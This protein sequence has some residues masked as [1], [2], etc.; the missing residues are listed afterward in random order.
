MEA[1]VGRAAL[2]LLSRAGAPGL[3]GRVWT[4]V[5][6]HSWELAGSEAWALE[7]SPG[8]LGS[9]RLPLWNSRRAAPTAMVAVHSPP[10]P[11]PPGL[12]GAPPTPANRAGQPTSKLPWPEEQ[13]DPR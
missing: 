9:A 13:A 4:R 12:R 10:G 7:G 3:A 1:F 8:A 5:P 11:L 6:G 2:H